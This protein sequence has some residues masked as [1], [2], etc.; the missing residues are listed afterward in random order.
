MKRGLVL[1]LMFLIFSTGFI[2]SAILSTEVQ[3][4]PYIP[5]SS[6]NLT[7]NVIV[8]SDSSSSGM[9]ADYIWYKNTLKILLAHF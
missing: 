2:S 5:I 4:T 6:E 1:C 7:C 3:I 9:T 8:I